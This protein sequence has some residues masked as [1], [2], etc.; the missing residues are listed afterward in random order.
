M[1]GRTIFARVMAEAAKLG[2]TRL[3]RIAIILALAL[4]AVMGEAGW[5]VL[6][7]L[8]LE[9]QTV[10]DENGPQPQGVPLP[11]DPSRVDDGG[12]G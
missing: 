6:K 8:K 5:S 1:D 10:A 9:P 4:I 7:R 3:E 12:N 2:L 11:T